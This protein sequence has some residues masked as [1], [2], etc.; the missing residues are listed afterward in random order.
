[1][2]EQINIREVLA[3]IKS[4]ADGD[5][6]TLDF[7]Y[8]T[9][10]KKGLAGFKS[11]RYGAPIQEVHTPERQ[12]VA[13]KADHRDHVDYGT[14]PLTDVFTGKYKELLMSHITGYNQYKVV[15]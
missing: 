10:K 12:R 2:A 1:M 4:G 13:E 8:A 11:F 6:F 14:I 9:G 15:H 7:I 5:S 3:R